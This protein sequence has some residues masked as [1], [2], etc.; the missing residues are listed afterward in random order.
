VC[1]VCYIFEYRRDIVLFHSS[2]PIA[3][4]GEPEAPT[5]F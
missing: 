1:N 3:R 2:I 4:I 5:S